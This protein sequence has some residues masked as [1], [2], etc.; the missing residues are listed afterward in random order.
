[1]TIQRCVYGDDGTLT[2][3]KATYADGCVTFTTTHFSTYIISTVTLS[4]DNDNNS[5]AGSG[6]PATGVFLAFIPVVAV[7]TGV[8]IA[9]KRK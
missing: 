7:E 2:D 8:V 1:M 6:N 5:D 9:K 3:M 4:S